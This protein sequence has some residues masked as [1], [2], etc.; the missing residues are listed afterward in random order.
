MV[1]NK[2]KFDIAAWKLF[3]ISFM[4]IF[5]FYF[6]IMATTTQDIVLV[7]NSIITLYNVSNTHY[8]YILKAMMDLKPEYVEKI[9]QVTFSENQSWIADKC[10]SDLKISE[11]YSK[12]TRGCH[13]NP[14]NKIFVWVFDDERSFREVLCHELLHEIIDI[15]H[16]A[17]QDL[18]YLIDGTGICYEDRMRDFNV[19]VLVDKL[20][21]DYNV[22]IEVDKFKGSMD[23][24][25]TLS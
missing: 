16:D 19:R 25:F 17:E 11:G 12:V 15:E 23:W 21:D 4:I 20:D 7:D 2:D 9:N 5:L 22:K 10:G 1:K 8:E 3:P 6:I 14:S 24:R 18:A 13:H